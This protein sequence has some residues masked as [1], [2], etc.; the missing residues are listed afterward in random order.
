MLKEGW[1]YQNAIVAIMK[2]SSDVPKYDAFYSINEVR[3]QALS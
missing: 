1:F 2:M 3:V